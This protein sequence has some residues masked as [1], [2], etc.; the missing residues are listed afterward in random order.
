MLSWCVGVLPSLTLCCEGC[1]CVPAAPARA[2]PPSAPCPAPTLPPADD[3][4]GAAHHLPRAG[5]AHAL[6][7]AVQCC[8]CCP[9]RRP[10]PWRAR[11]G[12]EVACVAVAGVAGCTC[13]PRC[14]A[15]LCTHR[16][17]LAA[18]DSG[19]SCNDTATAAMVMSYIHTTLVWCQK[20]TQRTRCSGCRH[21]RS[22]CCRQALGA[23]RTQHQHAAAAAP[24]SHAARL[25]ARQHSSGRRKGGVL[26]HSQSTLRLS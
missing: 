16:R 13:G 21:T 6:R 5:V 24:A 14:C 9:W 26:C 11:C 23:R 4:G 25:E 20:R 17:L 7:A 8:P 18:V 15:A 12:H 10:P 19:S 3:C 22:H 2:P 1:C